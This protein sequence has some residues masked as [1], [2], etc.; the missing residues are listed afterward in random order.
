MDC[1][2]SEKW[3]SS[4]GIHSCPVSLRLDVHKKTTKN[5]EIR[6]TWGP[7]RR[8]PPGCRPAMCRWTWGQRGP[9]GQTGK[10]SQLQDTRGGKHRVS[11]TM[12]FFKLI[13]KVKNAQSTFTTVLY[14]KIIHT[15]EI[16][17]CLNYYST[18]PI[19]LPPSSLQL[20]GTVCFW[21]SSRLPTRQKPWHKGGDGGRLPLADT[22][23][24]REEQTIASHSKDNA[25]K[26]KHGA[27]ETKPRMKE[28]GGGRGGGGRGGGGRDF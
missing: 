26:W 18:A 5:C 16:Q 25:W 23:Q 10:P 2:P 14:F 28:E 8:Q 6:T 24:K 1:N 4:L 20:K 3:Y 21:A 15:F 12:D 22:C 9:S 27:K 19:T 7:T 17:H 11:Q 13:Q